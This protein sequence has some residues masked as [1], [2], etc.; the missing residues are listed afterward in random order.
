MILI[1]PEYKAPV[2]YRAPTIRITDKVMIPQEDH[3]DI[4]FVGLLI[5]PRG[6]TL[7]NLEK[8]TG[9]KIIIRGKGSVKEG[10]I[11]RQEPLP[12]EDEPLHAWVTAD[13]TDKVADAVGRIREMIRQGIE[14]PEGEN[15]LLRNQLQELAR[16]NGTLREDGALSKLKQIQEAQAI[17]TN[18]IFCLVCGGAGHLS[19]DCKQKRPGDT[20]REMQAKE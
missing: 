13:T 17:V 18:Q 20:F 9:A 3:P 4:N 11:G 8:E 10:K 6:N 5:G 16:L 1:N 14:V 2:D 19:A 15:I 7:K 12:G